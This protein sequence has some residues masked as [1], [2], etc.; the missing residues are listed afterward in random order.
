[1]AQELIIQASSL[2]REEFDPSELLVGLECGGSD[3]SSGLVSNPVVGEFS[4]LLVRAGGTAMFSETPEIV[5]AEHLLAERAT[6]QEAGQKILQLVADLEQNLTRVGE[7]LRSG[8]PSPGNKDGG[9]STI[10]EKSLGCI[11]KGGTTP[12]VEVLDYAETP[13]KKD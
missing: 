6:T 9:L 12:I 3:S 10:E 4:D 1:M 8:Q 7:D 13:T 2:E 11:H 5:G